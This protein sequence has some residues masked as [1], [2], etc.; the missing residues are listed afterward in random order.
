KVIPGD[1][2]KS[3]LFKKVQSGEMPPED[4]KPRPTADE[5]ATLKAWIDAGA[6]AVNT[7]SSEAPGQRAFLS[8]KDALAAV[9]EHLRS[10]PAEEHPFQRYFTLTHLHNH[11]A[12][13]DEDLRWQ[14]AALA[15][16]VNSLSWKPRIVLPRAVDKG[17]TVFAVDLRDLDWDRRRVW[18]EVSKHY[19]YGLK[20]DSQRDNELRAVA[21]EVYRLTGSDLP[22]LRADWFVATA[23]RPP[24][25]HT[26]LDLPDTAAKL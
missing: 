6:P 3:R 18:D 13:S 20:L 21:A 12:V 25:Y 17:E 26:I 4:E 15:K 8:E 23:T 9:R 16:A 1:A 11:P 5:I 14:R 7:A 24:L 2:A 19:P 22:V 10:L